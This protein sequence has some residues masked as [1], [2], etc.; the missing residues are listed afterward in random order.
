MRISPLWGYSFTRC[1]WYPAHSPGCR[2]HGAHA[3]AG[4]PLRAE[5][6]R[7]CGGGSSYIG[8][9][10]S[11]R[12]PQRQRKTTISYR[13]LPIFAQ[14]V[15]SRRL[16]SEL[17]QLAHEIVVRAD[18][19]RVKERDTPR[20]SVLLREIVAMSDLAFP[21]SA[22]QRRPLSLLRGR[23]GKRL[24]KASG[25]ASTLRRCVSSSPAARS[26]IPVVSRRGCLRL[27][28]S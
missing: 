8:R 9:R 21:G 11:R 23:R 16:T 4:T 13:T 27:C 10:I 25:L 17:V 3:E 26:A 20:N 6:V 1:P 2:M 14:R 22:L 7:A 12:L 18:C 24:G 15:V 19:I 28:G 5:G